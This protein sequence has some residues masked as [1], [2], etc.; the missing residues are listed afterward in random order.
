M[1]TTWR[2]TGSSGGPET[3]SDASSA[4]PRCVI[5]AAFQFNGPSWPSESPRGATAPTF[6]SLYLSAAEREPYDV[7]DTW[8]ENSFK[9]S[10]EVSSEGFEPTAGISTVGHGHTGVHINS[11]QP[12]YS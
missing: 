1:F 7:S 5:I 9:T 6:G 4:K 8:F 11:I 3:S 10:F 2:G 12:K